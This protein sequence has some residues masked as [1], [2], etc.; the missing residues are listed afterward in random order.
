MATGLV[1]LSV[2]LYVGHIVRTARHP[3]WWRWVLDR[4]LLGGAVFRGGGW[5]FGLRLVSV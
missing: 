1:G 4:V 2:Q 3:R 5:F